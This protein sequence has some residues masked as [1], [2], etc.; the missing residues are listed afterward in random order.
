MTTQRRPKRIS[1]VTAG[2]GLV[3]LAA[4][5]TGLNMPLVSQGPVWVAPPSADKVV[6]PLKSDAAATARGKVIFQQMCSIC[7][8]NKGKGDGMAGIALRP[9]PSN[10]T[11]AT[12]QAQT[13]GALHWKLTTGKAPMAAYGATLKDEQRWELVNYIRTLK[14]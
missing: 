9:R 14:N 2:L 4:F 7:H 12:V 1:I 11:S 3:L 6:N 13:D 10:L 8:G 5:N